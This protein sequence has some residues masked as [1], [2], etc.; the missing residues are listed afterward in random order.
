MLLESILLIVLVLL[1]IGSIFSVKRDYGKL[2]KL[3]TRS[4]IA[5][6]SL[7]SYHL[8][9][10]IIFNLLAIWLIPLYDL[11]S[12]II[13]GTFIILGIQFYIAGIVV[14]R[15]FKRMSGIESNKLITNGIYNYSRNPQNVGWGLFIL[16]IA[17]LGKSLISILLV[18]FFWIFLHV[19]IVYIEEP[20]LEEIFGEEYKKYCDSTSRYFGLNLKPK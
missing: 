16:G 12:L 4:V 10:L 9:L 5:V 6:W 14:F 20:Y 11:I 7:Y 17:V 8:V 2:K 18:V 19:Y 13:G 1:A 3:S 15:S